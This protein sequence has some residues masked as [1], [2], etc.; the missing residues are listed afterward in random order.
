[1]S[2]MRLAASEVELINRAQFN[3]WAL[4]LKTSSF[5]VYVSL[6]KQN[7]FQSRSWPRTYDI[8]H[9][10]YENGNSGMHT[11]VSGDIS[12]TDEGS[13]QG[14][15]AFCTSCTLNMHKTCIKLVGHLL[16]V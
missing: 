10:I 7:S 9:D 1:M 5:C 16:M 4:I 3:E 13:T 12:E 8:M 2:S 6:A 14:G 11:P 15:Y